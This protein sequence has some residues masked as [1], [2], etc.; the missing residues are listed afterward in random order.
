MLLIIGYATMYAHGCVHHALDALR[1]EKNDKRNE[2]PVSEAL[3]SLKKSCGGG[4][5]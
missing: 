4:Q 2:Y 5:A 1:H 3:L